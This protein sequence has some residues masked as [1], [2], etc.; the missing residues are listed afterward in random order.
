MVNQY[1]N[2]HTIIH[3]LFVYP[4]LHPVLVPVGPQDMIHG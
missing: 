3:L 4:F 2:T 1:R